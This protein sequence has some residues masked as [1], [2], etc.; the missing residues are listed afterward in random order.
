MFTC[1][2][3]TKVTIRWI[4]AH[5]GVDGNEFADGEAKSAALLGAG[6]GVATGSGTGK[7]IVRLTA[8]AKRAVRQRIR[9]RWEKQWERKITSVPTKRLVQVPNK[10]TLRLY[11]GLS[12]PQCTVLLQLDEAPA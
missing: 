6:M 9:E 4:P 5:V 2:E 1:V 8:A 3:P 11:E 10:K 7:P 12:K